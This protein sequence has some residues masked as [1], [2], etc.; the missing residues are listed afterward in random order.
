M[1]AQPSLFGPV[2]QP[3]YVKPEPASVYQ[4]VLLLRKKGH[5]VYRSGRRAHTVDGCNVPTDWLLAL[6]RAAA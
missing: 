2:V 1:T 5:K 3:R 4:A 6:A